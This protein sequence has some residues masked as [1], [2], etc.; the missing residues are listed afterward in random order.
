MGWG[1][2]FE[3]T[4]SRRRFLAAAG[5]T[6][7]AATLGFLGLKKFWDGHARPVGYGELVA[8]PARVLDLPRGFRYHVFSRTGD[9]MDD[10]LLVPGGHDGMATFSGT[11]GKKR[12]RSGRPGKN[13]AG[14]SP[15]L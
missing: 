6:A 2:S 14:S 11:G 3:M 10:G 13:T 9:P 4:V 12:L 1:R 15:D 5:V 8:D 7:G